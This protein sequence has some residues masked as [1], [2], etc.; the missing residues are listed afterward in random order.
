MKS[1]N[2][3]DV[4]P[5]QRE[6]RDLRRNK[7]VTLAS[8]EKAKHVTAVIGESNAEAAYT[9]FQELVLS[10]GE[11]RDSKALYNAYR[12][13][14]RTLPA[15]TVG[16]R[17]DFGRDNGGYSATEVWKWENS[18]VD[19]LEQLLLEPPSVHYGISLIV[20]KSRLVQQRTIAEHYPGWSPDEF[21]SGVP[22][23]KTIALA[24][25]CSAWVGEYVDIV[26]QDIEQFEPE[27]WDPNFYLFKA[28]QSTLG[29]IAVAVAIVDN[30]EPAEVWVTH[31]A[32]SEAIMDRRNERFLLDLISVS[33]DDTNSSFYLGAMPADFSNSSY[34][35]VRWIY[36]SRVTAVPDRREQSA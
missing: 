19:R 11:D 28:D 27:I 2:N 3:T 5:V 18:A 15:S 23:P 21:T 4:S 24:T 26:E 34:F 9:R 12:F 6:L 29:A 20:Y 33:T 7:G 30:E 17:E 16:R 31:A 32:S 10:L 14:D 1:E 25:D 35:L 22:D 13:Q 36:R 8:L